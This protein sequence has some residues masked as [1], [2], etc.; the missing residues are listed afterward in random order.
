[1]YVARGIAIIVRF[2]RWTVGGEVAQGKSY[3][4]CRRKFVIYI[5]KTKKDPLTPAARKNS[6]WTFDELFRSKTLM[7]Q[8][9]LIEI[10]YKRH[11]NV[12]DGFAHKP[13]L[14][15]TRRVN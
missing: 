15:K 3:D 7:G 8:I 10:R 5:V 9:F 1:M 13:N 11:A 12:R 6:E 4:V 14:R 2:G